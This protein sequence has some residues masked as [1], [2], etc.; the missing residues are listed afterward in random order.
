MGLQIRC[1]LHSQEQKKALVW[2]N[3]PCLGQG[4]PRAGQAEG[5]KIF[6]LQGEK[7]IALFLDCAWYMVGR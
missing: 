6:Y 3:P 7:A 2:E 1:N 4:L 5:A